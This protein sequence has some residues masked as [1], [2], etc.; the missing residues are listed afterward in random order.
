MNWCTRRKN[1]KPS[2]TNLIKPLLKC[3]DTK[4]NIYINFYFICTFYKL[5]E[6]PSKLQDKTIDAFFPR[7]ANVLKKQSTT[8]PLFLPQ[9]TILK[10]RYF[11]S[12]SNPA[13]CQPDSR[14]DLLHFICLIYSYNNKILYRSL[15]VIFCKNQIKSLYRPQWP[16]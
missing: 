11:F 5:V 1:S 12:S 9:V 2:L 10:S 14:T 15:T 7:S 8:E 3:Q 6:I 13:W 16:L 4:R